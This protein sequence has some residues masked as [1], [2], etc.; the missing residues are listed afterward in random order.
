MGKITEL[1]VSHIS[2]VKRP[3]TGKHVILRSGNPHP[4]PLSQGERGAKVFE[5]RKMDAKLQRVYGIV[6]APGEVDSQGDYADADVIRR[7][8]TAFL[9]N[10]NQQNVDTEHSFSSEMACVAETWLIRKGDPLFPDEPD[11]AWA[12]GIQIYDPDLW[13]RLESG[14]LTGLSL[15]GLA[16]YEQPDVA[17]KSDET[18]T[19]GWFMRWLRSAGLRKEAI[20]TSE[21][22]EVNEEQIKALLKSEIPTL[23]TATLA[24]RKSAETAAAE[25][26]ARKQEMADLKKSVADLTEL[27]KGMAHK[28]SHESGATD[29]GVRKSFLD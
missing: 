12:V 11:G 5:I 1:H 29:S 9:R 22:P 14:E 2:L 8:A 26:T 27:V 25:E 15:A 10:Y 24:A 21:E 3:A 18:E 4:Q 7:A 13:R 23:V 6:Y 20:P 19:P 16:Q 17:R 28:G